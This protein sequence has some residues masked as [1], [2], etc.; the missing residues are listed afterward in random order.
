MLQSYVFTSTVF[1]VTVFFLVVGSSFICKEAKR[2][3]ALDKKVSNLLKS[4]RK[5]DGDRLLASL[6]KYREKLKHLDLLVRSNKT[7]Y[8]DSAF[9]A[10][11]Q[12]INNFARSNFNITSVVETFNWN[13][14]EFRL[15]NDTMRNI[16]TLGMFFTFHCKDLIYSSL[17]LESDD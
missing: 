7:Y 6:N 2:L 1:T 3:V 10:V 5:D 15:F 13:E 12:G 14:S 11:E 8:G 17:A 16:Q 9:Y 4:K